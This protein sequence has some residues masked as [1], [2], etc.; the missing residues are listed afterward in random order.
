MPGTIEPVWS[1]PGTAL[2]AGS[3]VFQAI[4]KIFEKLYNFITALTAR[5]SFTA[6]A[7]PDFAETLFRPFLFQG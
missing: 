4:C 6:P 1:L 3:F 7:H 5:E 2:G